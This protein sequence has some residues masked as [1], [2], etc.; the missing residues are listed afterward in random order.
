MRIINSPLRMMLLWI[1]IHKMKML[2][3]LWLITWLKA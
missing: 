2:N 1:L 3:E